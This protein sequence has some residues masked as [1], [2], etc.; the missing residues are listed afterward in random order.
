M[1]SLGFSNWAACFDLVSH[2]SS[3]SWASLVYYYHKTTDLIH[4][5]WV[6]LALVNFHPTPC[7]FSFS[8]LFFWLISLFITEFFKWSIICSR[9]CNYHKV[10]LDEFSQTKHTC[11]T[12]TQIKEQNVIQHHALFHH[13]L[14]P[15]SIATTYFEIMRFI[16]HVTDC[17]C[18][19][20]SLIPV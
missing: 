16:L 17:S 3:H 5:M 11:V 1:L 20:F 14:S 9:K 10:R 15:L 12:N 2:S 7:F 8:L 19:L 6:Y 18:S 4:C 13:C